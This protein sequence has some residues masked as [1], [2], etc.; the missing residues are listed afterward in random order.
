MVINKAVEAEEK[1]ITIEVDI[2]PLSRI[3]HPKK[4]MVM[5]AGNPSTQMAGLGSSFQYEERKSMVAEAMEEC[6][7][8]SE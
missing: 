7:L 6:A 4:L 5:V 3:R 8:S 2:Q 1:I